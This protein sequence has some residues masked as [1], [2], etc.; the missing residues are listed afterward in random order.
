AGYDCNSLGGDNYSSSYPGFASVP[1]GTT[2]SGNWQLLASSPAA[3]AG[4]NLTGTFTAGNFPTNSSNSLI[5]DISQ[6]V[7]R[8]V[9]AGLT[10]GLPVGW[11]MGAYEGKRPSPPTN[12]H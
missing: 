6:T 5:A 9:P 8:P 11:S 1:D 7:T 3:E 2:G 4:A 10:T 12:L